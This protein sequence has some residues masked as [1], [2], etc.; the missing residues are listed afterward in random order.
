L[1]QR[2]LN[3]GRLEETSGGVEFDAALLGLKLDDPVRLAQRIHAS[4]KQVPIVILSK[5]GHN[6]LLRRTLMFSPFLGSEV[7]AWP[8]DEVDEL[9]SALQ[10]AVDRR[11]QRKRYHDTV[12]SAEIRLEMLPLLQPE[13]THYLD[14]LLDHVPIGVVTVD[15]SGTIMTLN[16]RACM[17]LGVSERRALGA[18]FIEFFPATEKSRL[19]SLIDG[20]RES[21]ERFRRR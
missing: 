15:T 19:S 7:M 10:K 17:T 12:A 1:G 5:P 21:P 2:D 14:Q 8:S 9:P 4:D 11:R 20:C 13:A 16:S 6:D 18:S 3:F